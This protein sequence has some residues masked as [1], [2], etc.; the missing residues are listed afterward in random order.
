[1]VINSK[2]SHL[3]KRDDYTLNFIVFYIFKTH[4]IIGRTCEYPTFKRWLP[5]DDL[6]NFVRQ[7][8]VFIGNAF[9]VM[10]AEFNNH[11]RI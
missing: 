3:K 7:L 6:L 10:R 2:K 9:R 5:A 4:I 1:M 11:K 8:K